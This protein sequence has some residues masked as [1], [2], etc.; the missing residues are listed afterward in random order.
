[1]SWA[2]VGLCILT[3]ITSCCGSLNVTAITWNVNSAAKIRS[4]PRAL[5]QIA[6]CDVV[7]L[8]ETLSTSPDTC[9]LLPGFVGQ[10]SLAIPTNRRPSRGLS[11]FFRI[12]TFVD[13]AL[14]Q[15]LL[16]YFATVLCVKRFWMTLSNSDLLV[17]LLTSLVIYYGLLGA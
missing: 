5:A 3:G 14:S 8:Q 11:S 2:L 17:L 4:D 10:H 15:V 9:L 16:C 6:S 13:G 12:E 1:M 7:F